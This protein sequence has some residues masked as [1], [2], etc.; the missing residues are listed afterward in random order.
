MSSDIASGIQSGLRLRR[1]RKRDQ[2]KSALREMITRQNLAPG[3]CLPGQVELARHFGTTVVTIYHALSEMEKEGVLHRINGKGTFVGPPPTRTLQVCL[4]LQ[5]EHLDEPAHNPIYWPYVQA[6]FRVFLTAVRGK[7]SFTTRAVE[8]GTDPRTIA[9]EFATYGAVF[10]HWSRQPFDLLEYLVKHRVVPV[11]AFGKPIPGVRCLTVD[12]DAVGGT[13][14]S[15]SYLLELGYRRVAIVA[16][17]HEWGEYW[18]AG[19]REALS[20]FGLPYDPNLVVRVGEPQS[21]GVRAAIRLVQQGLPCDAVFVDSDLR[22]LGVVEGFRQAGVR[23]P[24]EVGVMGYEGLDLAVNHP[25]YLTSLEVPRARMIAAA[26]AILER[27]RGR[28]SSP[29]HLEFVG[30]I[31]PGRTT[32]ARTSLSPRPSS[33]RPLPAGVPTVPETGDRG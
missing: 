12:H 21:E 33:D 29:Q 20:A 30:E 17:K 25:P 31:L 13:R 27:S 8:P 10:F 9:P 28:A 6:L 18:L 3:D 11:V 1:E 19:Y 26:L 4:V 24:E 14:K 32:S 15:V 5:G 22:A 2:I 16:S 7:W 23:V